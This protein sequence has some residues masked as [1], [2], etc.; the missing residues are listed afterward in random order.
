MGLRLGPERPPLRPAATP[1]TAPSGLSLEAP[2][3]FP[4]LCARNPGTRIRAARAIALETSARARA[5]A[6]RG[7]T[8]LR[9]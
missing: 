4:H 6:G 3:E 8:E 1:A 2:R 5:N 9:V 7:R